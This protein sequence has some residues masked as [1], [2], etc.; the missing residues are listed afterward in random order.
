MQPLVV[1][2]SATSGKPYFGVNGRDKGDGKEKAKRCDKSVR[3][4]WVGNWIAEIRAWE[5][6]PTKTIVVDTVSD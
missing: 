2:L 4:K 1:S 5:R 3:V 6:G